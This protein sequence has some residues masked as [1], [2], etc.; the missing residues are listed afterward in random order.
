MEQG[1]GREAARPQIVLHIGRNKAGSTTIQDVCLGARAAL[2]DQGI[3]YLLFGHLA[4]SRE[5]VAGCATFEELREHA[6]AR[7]GRTL[8]VS[9]EF[10]F[11][12]PAEYTEAAARAL[13][14]CDVRILAYIRRYDDWI[15]SAY[16]EE[17][18][19][20]MNLRDADAYVAWM[21]PR[22]PA[23]PYLAKWGEG[24]GWDALRV[25]TLDRRDLHGGEL[26]A[27]FAHAL[28]VEPLSGGVLQSNP[29]PHWLELELVRR[30]AERNGETEWAGVGHAEA[31]PLLAELRPMLNEV[32]PR[33]YLGREARARL[34]E[35]Y[36]ADLDRIG[37]VGDR[38][39][40]PPKPAPDAPAGMAPRFEDAPPVLLERFFAATTGAR[41]GAR[42]HQA[43]ERARRLA[44]EMGYGPSR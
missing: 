17:T 29:S 28:G 21:A 42:H 20:G 10:M 34:L 19:K 23:W 4:G 18:R 33:T 11:G 41:F 38:T 35:L 26:L 44:R 32:A 31:E 39:L 3:D 36:A 22:T 30:L 9:N 2:S 43:F 13:H 40:S 8:L 6:L 24:F 25:R 5:D 15:V 1:P 16:A 12:W 27:D 37:R 7:P 14:D